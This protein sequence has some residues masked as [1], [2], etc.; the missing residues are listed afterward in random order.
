MD[1]KSS[2]RSKKIVSET[3]RGCSGSLCGYCRDRKF[4][5]CQ[6]RTVNS[7]W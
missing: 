1:I 5:R 3:R 6:F 7:R 4:W 2:K